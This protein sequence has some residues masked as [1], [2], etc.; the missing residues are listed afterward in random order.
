MD[1]LPHFVFAPTRIAKMTSFLLTDL[2]VELLRIVFSFVAVCG[3]D[4]EHLARTNRLLRSVSVPF[5]QTHRYAFVS[6]KD[7][8][9]IPRVLRDLILDPSVARYDNFLP[10][11]FHSADYIDILKTC[12]KHGN[13]KPYVLI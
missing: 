11:K 7:P 6:D 4:I 1:F 3:N 12:E 9:T 13:Y 8:C 5:I 2:S 10:K